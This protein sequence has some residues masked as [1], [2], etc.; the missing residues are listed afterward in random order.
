MQAK[1]EKYFHSKMQDTE[2]E[3]KILSGV[4][5]NHE[6]DPIDSNISSS[7]I[8]GIWNDHISSFLILR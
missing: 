5:Y 1:Y 7:Q 2:V 3:N 4:P 8:P 6:T